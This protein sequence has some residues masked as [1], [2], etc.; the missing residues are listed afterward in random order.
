MFWLFMP[1]A[2]LVFAAPKVMEL[3]ADPKPPPVLLLAEEPKRPPPPVVLLLAPNGELVLFAAKGEEVLLEPKSPPPEAPPAVLLV[4]PKP[5]PL[6]AVP[7]LLLL[8]F[9]WPNKLPPV[10]AVVFPAAVFPKMLPVFDP[11]GE[12]LLLEAPKAEEPFDAPKPPK[13]D[14]P[15]EGLPNMA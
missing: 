10:F 7:V 3:L 6:F 14:V 9:A 13:P 5:K 12:L 4:A 2:V 8:A 15:A 11:N 1:K